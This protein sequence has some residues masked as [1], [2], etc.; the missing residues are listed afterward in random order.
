MKQ[1]LILLLLSFFLTRKLLC[2]CCGHCCFIYFL[3]E[4][5]IKDCNTIHMTINMWLTLLLLYT[6]HCFSYCTCTSSFSFTTTRSYT[7]SQSIYFSSEVYLWGLLI[8]WGDADD[9]NIDFYII[10]IWKTI[11]TK[12]CIIIECVLHQQLDNY[13]QFSLHITFSKQ[14]SS[15]LS[16]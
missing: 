7:S 9:V 12:R 1:S 11:K 16:L 15:S 6:V 3:R 4:I 10:E 5:I 2:C 8:S 13:Q 14:S